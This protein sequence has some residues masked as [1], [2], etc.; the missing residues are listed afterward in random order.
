MKD[1][2]NFASDAETIAGAQQK[3]SNKN[4]D[5]EKSIIHKILEGED[6]VKS[7]EEMDK[8]LLKAGFSKVWSLNT[9]EKNFIY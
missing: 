7:V 1:L 2:L 4:W 5:W 3:L 6:N 8:F 9:P